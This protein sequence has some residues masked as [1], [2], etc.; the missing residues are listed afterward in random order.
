M[1]D[2]Y[3]KKLNIRKDFEII[4]FFLKN[5]KMTTIFHE[6]GFLNY[7]SENKFNEH[8]LGVFNSKEII[9]FIPIGLINSER[10]FIAKSPYGA[11]FGGIIYKEN[12]NFIEIQ[13]ILKLIIRYFQDKNITQISLTFP[14]KYYSE[15]PILQDNIYS[16]LA[17][18]GFMQEPEYITS[19]IDLRNRNAIEILHSAAKRKYLNAKKNGIYFNVIDNKDVETLKFFYK[20]LHQTL[21]QH[22][23]IPTHTIEE[24]T[25]L[26]EKFPDRI[27]L[28]I[29]KK[30]TLILSGIIIFLA[31]PTT[32]LAFYNARNL[33]QNDSNSLTFL[34][35][36]SINWLKSKGYSYLDLGTSQKLGEELNKGLFQFKE[37]L[38]S[39]SVLRDRWIKKV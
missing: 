26:F 35:A 14:P 28:C 30:D 3:I 34:F 7:H 9:A 1:N 10:N 36:E 31:T 17:Q 37:S 19:I 20:M 5:N 32:A 21:A 33:N 18:I 2:F 23:T 29:S 24:L 38:G 25:Y 13:H 12:L 27:K 6:P 4:D 39:N 11:S 15:N 22:N 8:N 16:G